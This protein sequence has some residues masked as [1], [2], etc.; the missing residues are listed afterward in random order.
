MGD[1]VLFLTSWAFNIAHK[2]NKG[3]QPAHH[4]NPALDASLMFMDSLQR[5]VPGFSAA[6]LMLEA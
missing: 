5:G 4:R 3:R 2:I 6:I 1:L